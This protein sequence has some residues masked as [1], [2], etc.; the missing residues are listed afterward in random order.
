[1]E[2]K[3]F[4]GALLLAFIVGKMKLKTRP[5]RRSWPIV[6]LALAVAILGVG[7]LVFKALTGPAEGILIRVY[8][9]ADQPPDN[10]ERGPYKLRDG[11]PSEVGVYR[12]Y[13]PIGPGS[14]TF[15]LL[16][17]IPLQMVDENEYHGEKVIHK[18]D[19]RLTVGYPA[20]WQNSID[21]YACVEVDQNENE[22][23]ITVYY[24]EYGSAIV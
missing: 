9:V 21:G 7:L 12:F 19:G 22:V 15:E 24:W 2:A 16:D 8:G 11:V 17:K 5:I 6:V 10:I 3:Y 18:I 14:G 1:M 20:Q 23:I 4:N 13:E